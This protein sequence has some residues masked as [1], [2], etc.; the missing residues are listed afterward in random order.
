[1]SIKKQNIFKKALKM[2]KNEQSNHLEAIFSKC[3]DIMLSKG[4]DYSKEDRLGLFKSVAQIT[5]STPAAV[6]LNLIATKVARLSELTSGDGKTPNHES[7]EDN[8]I[9]LINYSALLSQ[10]IKEGQN[11]LKAIYSEDTGGQGGY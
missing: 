11:G 2:T 8:I 7:I 1:L 5:R 9:D 10:I 6:C 3:K 4:D